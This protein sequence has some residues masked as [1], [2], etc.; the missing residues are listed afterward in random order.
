VA[1]LVSILATT[2]GIIQQNQYLLLAGIAIVL[3]LLAIGLIRDRLNREVLSEQISEL[4]RNL[5]DR[6]SAMAFFQEPKDIRPSLQRALQ[7]DLCGVTLTST[8]NKEY[9]T[10]RERL[11]A[12]AKIRIMIIDPDSIA[13]EMSAQRTGNPKDLDYHRTRLDSAL[14]ELAYIYKSMRD[15]K[16][17][18]GYSIGSLSVRLLPYAP[19]FSILSMDARQK[20]GIAFIEL[21]PH[22]FGYMPPVVF[23]LTPE[24][25]QSWH[26]YFVKQ[27]DVM[28]DAAKPW[29]PKTYLDK[30]PFAKK[31]E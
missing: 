11:Q 16:P 31:D 3:A 21:Y 28:W 22:K 19:S 25:D 13:I 1:I 27:F 10:L 6:P 2:F 15:T 9:G 30:I 24:R 26:D 23:D 29:D 7:I 18:K 20:D 8:L 12:G 5:P 17:K 14:R 4:K